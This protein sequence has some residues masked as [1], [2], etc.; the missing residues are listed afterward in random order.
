[1]LP[2]RPSGVE[3][4][5][6][7]GLG[8]NTLS[9][10]MVREN[11]LRSFVGVHELG[12]EWVETDV[13]VTRDRVAVLWHDDHVRCRRKVG[14]EAIGLHQASPAEPLAQMSPRDE[15]V[16]QRKV[17]ELALEEFRERTPR[18]E[19]ADCKHPTEVP[20]GRS[21]LLHAPEQGGHAWDCQMEDAVPTLQDALLRTPPE[22]AFNLELK[23]LDHEPLG[24][25]DLR[26]H[27]QVI[28]DEVAQF[29]G[30]RKICYSSFDPDA[31]RLAREMQDS[32]P[33]MFLT[34]GRLWPDPKF[35]SVSAAIKHAVECGLDGIVIKHQ[36]L[37]HEPVI[38]KIRAAGLHFAVYNL[39]GSDTVAVKQLVEWGCKALIVDDLPATLKSLRSLQ[40]E[41]SAIPTEVPVLPRAVAH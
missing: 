33:V 37:L 30:S 24:L 32:Y 25:D 12:V 14:G 13:Q 31:A 16:E 8:M 21:G 5:G 27:L 17:A 10:F 15:V 34:N 7:R 2:G 20:F 26:A 41:A 6:H 19:M 22:L 11:T 40:S 18:G 29:A 28:F 35:A 39:D 36:E 9:N 38:D 3:V 4:V 1:M 23:F